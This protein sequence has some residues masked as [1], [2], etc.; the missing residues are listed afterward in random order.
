[1]GSIFCYLLG[2]HSHGENV[3]H[4]YECHGATG[5][6]VKCSITNCTNVRIS[7]R[8]LLVCTFGLFIATNF[9]LLQICG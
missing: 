6:F 2:R 3:I 7:N 8:S 4:C 9:I 1:M 5:R